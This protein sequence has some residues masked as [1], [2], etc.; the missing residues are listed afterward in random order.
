M[1]GGLRILSGAMSSPSPPETPAETIESLRAA[2]AAAE[3]K[4]ALAEAR[5]VGAEAMVEHLRLEIAKLRRDRFGQRSERGRRL[6]DQLELQ[7]EQLEATAAEEACAAET[8]AAK[9]GQ[10]PGQAEVGSVARRRPVRGPLPAD[11]PLLSPGAAQPQRLPVLRR[12]G[13]QDRRRHH[14]DTGGGSPPVPGDP[15]RGREVLMPA[16]RDHP[17]ARTSP[18]RA[19]T[20]TLSTL[21][22]WVGAAATPAPLT[23]LIRSHVSSGARLHGDDATVPVLARV[24]TVTGRL[25]TYVRDDRPFA[26][27]APPAACFFFPATVRASTPPTTWRAGP[28]SSRPMPSPAS[29]R[30]TRR[31][32]VRGR[33]SKPDVGRMTGANSSCSPTSPRRPSPR[34]Q[35]LAPRKR[36]PALP[37]W[38]TRRYAGSTS[39]SIWNAR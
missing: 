5:A 8:A 25:W 31:G 39:S 24:R 32:E 13:L 29:T 33:S 18:A 27:P 9:A 1:A 2:L 11:L 12:Q 38:R 23:A 16:V 26:G 10:A 37:L 21:A 4:A 36:P 7:L 17:R 30:S 19:W 28:A 15:D 35:G 6:L 3:A 14:R 34:R 22:D 20:S